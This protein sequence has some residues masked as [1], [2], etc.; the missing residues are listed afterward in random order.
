MS[1]PP[2]Q[3]DSLQRAAFLERPNR[4]IVFADHDGERRR[5]YVANPGK[6]QEI[7]LPDVTELLLAHKPH[8]KTKWETMG[9]CW[10][11]RWPDDPPRAV[12]LNT[13]QVNDVAE[14]YLSAGLIPGLDHLSVV[15]REHTVGDSRFDFLMEGPD[16]EVLLEVK[17]VTLVEH[18]MALFPDA[19]SKRATKHVNE[20]TE[21]A[22]DGHP[23]AILFVVQGAADTFLPDLHNDL[24]F[25]RALRDASDHVDIHAIAVPPTL[26]ADGRLAFPDTPSPLQIPWDRLD[27]VL[28][29]G[30]LYLAVI[31]LDAPHT[32]EVGAL[33]TF[34]FPAGFYIYVGSAQKALTRRLARHGRSRKKKRWHIDYLCDFAQKVRGFPIRGVTGEPQLA[35]DCAVL[36]EV[37]P[38][39]FG[40][41]DC[42]DDGHL[43]FTGHTDPVHTPGFQRLLT[44]W[45]HVRAFTA[46]R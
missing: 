16:G 44:T 10:E 42:D 31:E 9:A 20:L 39:G 18:G 2:F 21:L 7:L 14:A 5:T 41:S 24:D 33:G 30:G 25:A 45:R 22:A 11:S 34:D 32:I 43:I 27:P 26:D 46:P 36:G 3:S 28:A 15:K 8:T 1:S 4:F 29:D 23:T 13:G 17:S 6:L 38:T 40:A 35:R 12:F 19:H 37:F